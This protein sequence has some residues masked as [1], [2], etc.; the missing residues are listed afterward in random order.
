V[1]VFRVFQKR[2][3]NLKA[4]YASLWMCRV[5]WR[6]DIP[7][8]CDSE[9]SCC[10]ALHIEKYKKTGPKVRGLPKWVLFADCEDSNVLI[11]EVP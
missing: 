4:F 7:G 3:T 6:D 1:S 8:R 11:W 9:E 10:S 5:F 2:F